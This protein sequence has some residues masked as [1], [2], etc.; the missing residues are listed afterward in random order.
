MSRL[1]QNS[2]RVFIH[3]DQLSRRLALP[4]ARAVP[5]LVSVDFEAGREPLEMSPGQLLKGLRERLHLILVNEHSCQGQQRLLLGPF[6]HGTGLID[7]HQVRHSTS[8]PERRVNR[9]VLD[10]RNTTGASHRRPSG[11]RSCSRSGVQPRIA[12][13]MDGECELGTSGALCKRGRCVGSFWSVQD[14]DHIST[15]GRQSA[16]LAGGSLCSSLKT[17][18]LDGVGCT[19]V[20][21]LRVC[22]SRDSTGGQSR[23]DAP[24]T[25]ETHAT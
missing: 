11:E 3:G 14:G 10:V 6:A 2:D 4:V 17:C 9:D 1:V 5:D 12:R 7:V 18:E 25:R 24:L 22:A 23:T 20:E 16:P 8:K 13:R 21:L 19:L 15:P